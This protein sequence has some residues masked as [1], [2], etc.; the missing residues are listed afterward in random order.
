[1]G[2]SWL[3][4]GLIGAFN[5]RIRRPNSKVANKLDHPGPWYD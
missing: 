4:L 5:E 1:M 2:W 3:A